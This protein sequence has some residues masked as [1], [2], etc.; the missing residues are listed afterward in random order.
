MKYKT[1]VQLVLAIIAMVNAF[2][3]ARTGN[4]AMT[5]WATALM[6]YMLREEKA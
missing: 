5:I 2:V 1:Y 6:L 3:T 4:V